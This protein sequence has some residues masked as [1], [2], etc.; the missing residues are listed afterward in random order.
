M[1]VPKLSCYF[2]D[3]IPGLILPVKLSESHNNDNNISYKFKLLVVK[4]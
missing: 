3:I 1:I 2:Y 4:E